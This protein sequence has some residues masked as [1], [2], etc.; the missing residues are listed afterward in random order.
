MIA[1]E[2]TEELD[3]ADTLSFLSDKREAVKEIKDEILSVEK[4]VDEC[5]SESR[6]FCKDTLAIAHNKFE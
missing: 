3:I 6:I 5:C 4:A 1:D 2:E